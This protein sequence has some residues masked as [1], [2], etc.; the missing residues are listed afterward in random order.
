[1]H[2]WIL[3]R[4]ERYQCDSCFEYLV[5]FPNTVYCQGSRLLYCEV[6]YKIQNFVELQFVV[7]L[8]SDYLIG[9]I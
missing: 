6:K 8:G 9:G 1:M 7:I 5:K 4:E 2:E 3:T